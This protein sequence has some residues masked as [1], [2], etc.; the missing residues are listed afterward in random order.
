M[1]YTSLREVAVFSEVSN[2]P[3]DLEC[4]R[5]EQVTALGEARQFRFSQPL[6]VSYFNVANTPMISFQSI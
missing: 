6:R 5:P 1:V 3:Q 2:K 4:L